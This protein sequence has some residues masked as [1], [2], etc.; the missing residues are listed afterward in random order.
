MPELGGGYKRKGTFIEY[1]KDLI[2]A[3]NAYHSHE[4]ALKVGDFTNTAYSM[5][6]YDSVVAIVKSPR[7]GPPVSAT[8]GKQ[9]ANKWIFTQAAK[10]KNSIM[11]NEQVREGRMHKCKEIDIQ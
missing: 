11:P 2:D 10:V 6:F 3:L 5:T 1:S 9:N 4:D 7:L 8:T